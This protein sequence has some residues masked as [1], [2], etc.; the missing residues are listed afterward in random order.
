MDERIGLAR[1]EAFSDGVFA[2]AITL[3]I[4]GIRVPAGRDLGQGLLDIW[5][6]YLA[7][8]T[9]FLTIGIIWINHHSIFEKTESADRMLLLLNTLLLMVV[10]F[11]P[12]P[13]RLVAEH[14][15]E[16]RDERVAALTYGFTF[17]VL[18]ICFQAL[19]RWI[20][21]RR[22]LIKPDVPQ[23]RVDDITRSFNPGIFMYTTSTALAFI[24]PLT[25]VALFLAI[26]AFYFLPASTLRLRRS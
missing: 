6:S 7:Y 20:A 12:F 13:T 23:T 22:R 26:A 21:I 15:R 3:L 24:S 18:A 11:I 8:A 9:S 14:I 4:L 1:L 2:I 17:I 10:A 25:S 16:S 19:W 5:P